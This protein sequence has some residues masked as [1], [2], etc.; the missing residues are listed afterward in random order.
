MIIQ[1][2]ET[3]S[4]K[5][6]QK[7]KSALKEK[8]F[9]PSEVKTQKARYIVAIGKEDIDIRMFGSMPGVKDIHRVS[10]AVKLVSRKWKTEYSQIDLG[11][12]VKISNGTFS[13]MAGPCSIEGEEQISETIDHLKQNNIRIMRGGVYKPRSSPYSFRGLGIDGL[14]EFSKQCKEAGIKIITEVMQKSQ[15]ED[16]Y[17]YTDIFQVGARNSQNYNLLDALGKVDKPIMI[18]RGLAGTIDEL[19]F[20]AEYVFSGGN[21]QILLCE[22]GIRSYEKAYR[23]VLDINAVPYLKDKTHLP[24][25]VDPSH[26]VGI[27]KYV[28]SLSLAAVMAGA[29]GIIVEVHKT[30]EKPIQTDNKI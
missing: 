4:E 21:E 10:D 3:I 17:E 9:K 5:D 12:G 6:L 20:S 11:D 26:A 7:L 19:L 30:P 27:R 1:V 15:I 2:Q 13:I 18:K 29:D 23:N 14:K 25:I 8:K 28:E 24:V 16:M 22:R